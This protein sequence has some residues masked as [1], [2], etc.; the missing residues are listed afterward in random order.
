M[1]FTRIVGPPLG[2]TCRVLR[3]AVL[4]AV[5]LIA[6]SVASGL[7]RVAAVSAFV[8]VALLREVMFAVEQLGDRVPSPRIS[9]E[10]RW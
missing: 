10:V 2:L 4:P 6:L 5:L 9:G 3:W 7:V 8:L 1:R